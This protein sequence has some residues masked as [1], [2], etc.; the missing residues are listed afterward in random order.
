M[1][2]SNKDDSSGLK[3]K[4][5][6]ELVTDFMRT[7]DAKKQLEIADEIFLREPRDYK[8]LQQLNRALRALT[9]RHPEV[10]RALEVDA[11]I[12]S[13]PPVEDGLVSHLRRENACK[14]LAQTRERWTLDLKVEKESKKPRR[15]DVLSDA[16]RAAREFER[17][18]R[19]SSD[20]LK[21]DKRP[22]SSIPPAPRKLRT[23]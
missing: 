14:E 3:S 10:Q 17:M 21:G 11:C 20:N 7:N 15:R 16:K 1:G 8:D 18:K 22:F 5:L 19:I 13:I 23:K 4:S 2:E 6:P 9:K 12:R